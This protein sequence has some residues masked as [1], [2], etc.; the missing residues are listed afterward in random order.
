MF[1]PWILVSPSLLTTTNGV[2]ASVLR[3][4]RLRRGR[5]GEGG[6]APPCRGPDRGHRRA[7][8][9]AEEPGALAV[10][11]TISL[12]E[13]SRA[14]SARGWPAAA[15]ASRAAARIAAPREAAAGSCPGGWAPPAA[16]PWWRRC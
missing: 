4:C 2:T 9:Q 3:P 1:L 15:A 8:R 5:R 11:L 10:H 16:R 13:D 7:E 6:G 14:T 12:D